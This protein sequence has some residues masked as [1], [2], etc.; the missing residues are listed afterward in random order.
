MAEEG[1]TLQQAEE[2]DGPYIESLL[3]QHGLPTADIQEKLAQFFVGY[4]GDERVCV[5]GL[6]V[7]GQAGLLRSVVVEQSAQGEGFGTA[8][9]EELEATAREEGVEALYLL[10]TTAAEFFAARGYARIDR[11]TAPEPIRQTTEFADLC[12]STATCLRTSLA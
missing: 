8:L 6:E 4:A 11:E 12:P 9:C 3:Q 1:L 10:T 7:H 2:S 5:G